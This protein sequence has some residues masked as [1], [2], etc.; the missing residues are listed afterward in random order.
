MITYNILSNSWGCGRQ[1]LI[2][3]KYFTS[4]EELQLNIYQKFR[5]KSFFNTLQQTTERQNTHSQPTNAKKKRIVEKFSVHAEQTE[6]RIS[7]CL[8]FYVP[9]IN[10]AVSQNKSAAP[11]RC[12]FV[13]D[14]N[15]G[16]FG[17]IL[18][19]LAVFNTL[20]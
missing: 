10:R 15:M 20:I 2:Y 8:F 7:I 4:A 16:V 6:N 19:G 17:E 1:N 13:A 12:K 18:L 11:I 9:C 3:N 14:C 5:R